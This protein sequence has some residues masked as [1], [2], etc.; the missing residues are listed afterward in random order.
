MWWEQEEE[1]PHLCWR[2]TLK[3]E[4]TTTKLTLAFC[5]S[6]FIKGEGPNRRKGPFFGTGLICPCRRNIFSFGS[7]VFVDHSC[8]AILVPTSLYQDASRRQKQRG[9]H[10]SEGPQQPGLTERRFF[11]AKEKQ[12][13]C[14]SK[15]STSGIRVATY[16]WKHASQDSGQVSVRSFLHLIHILSF[17]F[18]IQWQEPTNWDDRIMILTR[19]DRTWTW[20][21]TDTVRGESNLSVLTVLLLF[22]LLLFRSFHT[23]PHKRLTRLCSGTQ[24]K[25]AKEKV[26]SSSSRIIS[27][28]LSSF[29]L[30]SFQSFYLLLDFS[31]YFCSFISRPSLLFHLSFLQNICFS[32]P[33]ELTSSHNFVLH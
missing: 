23:F 27:L 15:W 12:T 7:Q 26:C 9:L 29:P 25:I 28:F 22:F 30:S 21:R 18:L 20:H 10:L 19:L 4:T 24:R 6:T 11:Q 32:F 13:I 8:P 14:A 3:I 2:T 16:R 33:I 5:H 31:I 17:L 1:Q